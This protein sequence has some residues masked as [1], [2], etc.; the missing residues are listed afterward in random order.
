MY[1]LEVSAKSSLYVTPPEQGSPYAR[2]FCK[3]NASVAE[4]NK[5]VAFFKAITIELSQRVPRS[6]EEQLHTAGAAYLR[7]SGALEGLALCKRSFLYTLTV[8]ED[9]LPMARAAIENLGMF[10]A[11]TIAPERRD[12]RF[13][14][15]CPEG[16]PT[17]HVAKE[18]GVKG[19]TVH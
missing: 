1:G 9:E 10:T 3:P 12:R 6:P 14:I 15:I 4:N 16:A 2:A 19:G 7:D 17:S 13:M 11:E 8:D 18:I 5:A